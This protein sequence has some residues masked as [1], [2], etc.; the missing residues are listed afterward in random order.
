MKPAIVSR[1]PDVGTTI[2]TVMTQ[3]AEQYG[4]LNLAQGFPDFPLPQ[5]L[6]EALARH[7]E[8]GHNQYAP[9]AGCRSCANASPSTSSA[10]SVAA[11]IRSPR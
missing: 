6:A 4:A 5:G 7:V 2:F 8:A 11:S 9:M 1:L 3:K 10:T